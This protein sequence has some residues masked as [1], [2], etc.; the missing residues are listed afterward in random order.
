MIFVQNG[1]TVTK[2]NY[3]YGAKQFDLFWAKRALYGPLVYFARG[4][5]YLTEAGCE[6]KVVNIQRMFTF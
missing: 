6:P 2:R 5:Y 1:Q 4:L 3:C